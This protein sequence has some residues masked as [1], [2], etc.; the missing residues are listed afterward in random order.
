MK[1]NWFKTEAVKSLNEELDLHVAKRE[2]L[3]SILTKYIEFVENN[4]PDEYMSKFGIGIA[5]KHHQFGQL[6]GFEFQ[7]DFGLVYL[8]PGSGYC[9][10]GDWNAKATG[11]NLSQMKNFAK[12]LPKWVKSG[13]E[14]I[15]KENQE[16]DEI[17]NNLS[18]LIETLK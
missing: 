5:A 11:S 18:D 9:I 12:S 13:L 10:A 1:T 6:Y 8:V 4:I 7:N 15:K 17:I 3:E 14:K 2:S 16:A